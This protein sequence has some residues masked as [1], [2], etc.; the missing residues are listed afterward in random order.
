MGTERHCQY[1]YESLLILIKKKQGDTQRLID[2]DHLLRDI[3]K[4]LIIEGRNCHS[5]ARMIIK[6]MCQVLLKLFRR[7]ITPGGI[8][9]SIDVT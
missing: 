9:S 4:R 5:Y 7:S 8:Q 6:L 2:E 1:K 3:W